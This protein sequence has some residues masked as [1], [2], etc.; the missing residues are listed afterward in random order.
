M[1]FLTS[2]PIDVAALAAAISAPD[3]GALV[4]FNGLVRDHH[5][6]RQVRSLSYS[7]YGPM[8][9][10]VCGDVVREAGER[11]PV[12][13]ALAH[14][15]GELTIGD[16]AVAVVVSSAHRSAAFDAC[17]WVIDEI[18]SRAPI[19]KREHYADGTEAWVDPTAPGGVVA[20]AK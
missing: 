3:R 6:G 16:S 17:R 2:Q 19:W 20:V 14:R 8:A 5:A 9:E 7:A 1:S 11:W 13:V 18:K 12:Q 15:L 4:T 10:K